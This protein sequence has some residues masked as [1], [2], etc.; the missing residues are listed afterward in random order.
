MTSD[1]FAEYIMTVTGRN[2][3]YFYDVAAPI[4]TYESI[5]MTKHFG[6][7]HGKGNDDYINCPM[8]KEQYEL[9]R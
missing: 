6:F 3:L 1:A 2:N 4:V 7:A 8:D 5:D 9:F